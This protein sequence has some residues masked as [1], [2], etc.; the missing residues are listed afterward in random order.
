[1]RCL[2]QGT[3]ISDFGQFQLQETSRQTQPTNEKLIDI[4]TDCLGSRKETT[5]T[6]PSPKSLNVA[7]LFI[8]PYTSS[9][10]E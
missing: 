4:D 6:L 2:R 1:M 9:A 8:E 5:W 10:R 7:G 3:E